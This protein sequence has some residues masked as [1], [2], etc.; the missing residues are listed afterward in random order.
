[1]RREDDSEPGASGTTPGEAAA[2]RSRSR[3]P[4]SPRRVVI[5]VLAIL[6]LIF[7]VVNFDPVNVNFLAFD[8]DARLF[9]V[10]VV[11]A[12]LG[13][14]IGYFVGRPSREERRILRRRD[15]TG[16]PRAAMPGV[17]L[18]DL[19][20]L[21][22]RPVAERECAPPS[23]RG[24]APRA[25]RAD[26]R[27]TDSRSRVRG[28][29]GRRR[30]PRPTTSRWRRAAREPDLRA[31]RRVP[32]EHL[33]RDGRAER[34]ESASRSCS[35]CPRGGRRPARRRPGRCGGPSAGGSAGPRS[36]PRPP[37]AARRSR[38]RTRRASSHVP[39]RVP[40]PP[41][42]GVRRRSRRRG[43]RRVHAHRP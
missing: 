43:R 8:T 1:M 31:V 27:G 21:R 30:A 17:A 7:A 38:C 12:A 13:F 33:S 6:L 24:S 11:S 19:L 41:H 32:F 28:G 10:I 22:E 42:R 5:V 37:R 14:A 18:L 16:R 26:R 25:R 39:S 2:S 4:A 23:A 15:A 9:T 3:H 29:S 35:G 40:A 34:H 20:L 36:P